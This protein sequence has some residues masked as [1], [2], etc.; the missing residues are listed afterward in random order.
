MPDDSFLKQ[1]SVFYRAARH[2]WGRCPQCGDLFRLSDAAIS[3]GADAPRDWLSR[4]ERLK[5]DIQA[6]EMDVTQEQGELQQRDIEVTRRERDVALRE[7]GIEAEA[8][9]RA[10]DLLKDKDAIKGLLKQARREGA[11]R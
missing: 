9:A 4:L 7:R 5:R 1:L 3:Y 11:Q 8:Q 2:L 10:R 6:K